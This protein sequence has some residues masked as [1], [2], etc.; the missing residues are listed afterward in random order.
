MP[1]LAFSGIRFSDYGIRYSC[2]GAILMSKQ[3]ADVVGH[4]KHGHSFMVCNS[5]SGIMELLMCYRRI[6]YRVRGQLLCKR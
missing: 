5:Q 1:L 6:R 4:W 2:I 3:V